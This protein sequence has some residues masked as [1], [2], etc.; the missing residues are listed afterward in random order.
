M[1]GRRLR[2][3]PDEARKEILQAAEAAIAELDFNQLT[4]ELLMERTG[5]TRSS[6]YHY[7]DSLEAVVLALFDRIESEIRGAVDEW[8][9]G[10]PA[11]DPLAATNTHL[12]RLFEIW[13]EHGHLMRA[14]NQVGARDQNANRLWRERIVDGYI[15]KTTDFIHRQIALG[16]CDAPDPEQLANA[17]ILM[18]TGV[19]TDHVS[20]PSPESPERVGRAIA[21]VWNLSIYGRY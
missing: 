1:A 5:M 16:L 4:V 6:F 20:G 2:R 14:I 10:P 12:T 21:R 17:L 9:M 19:A 8:L 18:N 3:A 13:A 15:E 11:E 7:F